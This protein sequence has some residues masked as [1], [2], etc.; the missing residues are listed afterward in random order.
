MSP[1]FGSFP[2]L[3]NVMRFVISPAL[4]FVVLLTVTLIP[5]TLVIGITLVTNVASAVTLI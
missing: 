1:T 3:S 4:V 2:D 5:G